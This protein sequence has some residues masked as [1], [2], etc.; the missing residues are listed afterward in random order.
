MVIELLTKIRNLYYKIKYGWVH[1][2]ENGA[3][4]EPVVPAHFEGETI[5][6][7]EGN[8]LYGKEAW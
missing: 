3:Q 2:N 8:L 1:P 6:D 7:K 5:F 4:P